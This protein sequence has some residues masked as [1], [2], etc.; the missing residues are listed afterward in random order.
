MMP[1]PTMDMERGFSKAGQILTP[2]QN[3]ISNKNLEEITANH[4]SMQIK[5]LT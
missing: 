3:L 4:I 2:Q 1:V 5:Q